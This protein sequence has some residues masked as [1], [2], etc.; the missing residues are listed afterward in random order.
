MI[1]F[2]DVII[3]KNIKH[4]FMLY[5][6]KTEAFQACAAVYVRHLLSGD[7]TWGGLAVEC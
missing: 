1:D 2:C 5:S 4:R 6:E 3:F 7:G